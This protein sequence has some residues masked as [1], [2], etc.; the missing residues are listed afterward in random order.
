MYES[1]REGVILLLQSFNVPQAKRRS[2][3]RDD[4]YCVPVSCINELTLDRN[5]RGEERWSTPKTLTLNTRGAAGRRRSER[6]GVPYTLERAGRERSSEKAK[7]AGW[8]VASS[9]SAASCGADEERAA[10][11]AENCSISS[12]CRRSASIAIAAGD[13]PGGLVR[14]RVW[15]IGVSLSFRFRSPR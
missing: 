14:A 7:R 2:T 3:S 6:R 12:A 11:C 8:E 5:Q 1:Q 10:A 13:L 4:A 9:T 15:G